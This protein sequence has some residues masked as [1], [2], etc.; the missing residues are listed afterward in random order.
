[1]TIV[2]RRRSAVLSGAVLV[3]LTVAG[4]GIATLS[5]LLSGTE[6]GRF[7]VTGGR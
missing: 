3:S 7:G 4:L 1:M 5:A 6:G 2:V